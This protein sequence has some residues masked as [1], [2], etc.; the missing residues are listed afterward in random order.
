[1]LKSTSEAVKRLLTE[2]NAEIKQYVSSQMKAGAKPS[3]PDVGVQPP[4][5]S[6][7]AGF[8]VADF[9]PYHA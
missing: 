4:V 1:M 8:A 5:A 2:R 7:L 9:A 3:L 6:Q